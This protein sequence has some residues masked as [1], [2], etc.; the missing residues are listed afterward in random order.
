MQYYANRFVVL[1][2]VVTL[3]IGCQQQATEVQGE[4]QAAEVQG[5]QQAADVQLEQESVAVEQLA[6]DVQPEQ[7]SVAIVQL[8]QAAVV[9]AAC[10]VCQFGLAGNGCELAV[11]IDGVAYFVDGTGINDHGD[12]H[13]DDGFC[14][15][16]R[17]ASVQGRVEDGRFVVKTFELLAVD[18]K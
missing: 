6:D 5:E 12:A 4:K 8:D 11:R 3:A 1:L 18:N 2:A 9:E 15:V 16:V 7:E 17:Q 14:S 13:S 10:G